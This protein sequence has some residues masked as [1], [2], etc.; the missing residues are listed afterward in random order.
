[1]TVINSARWGKFAHAA[2]WWYN[3]IRWYLS[4]T[5]SPLLY[6]Y[7][8]QALYLYI[9]IYAGRVGAKCKRENQCS[10]VADGV[11]LILIYCPWNSTSHRAIIEITGWFLAPFPLVSSLGTLYCAVV[12]YVW[13]RIFTSL[14]IREGTIWGI[15]LAIKYG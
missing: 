9:A 15:N 3:F 13:K 10:R 1:M 4:R 6:M 8:V 5:S 12:L 2:C 7:I 11:R 14:Q